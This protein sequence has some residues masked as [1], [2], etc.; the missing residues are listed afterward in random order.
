MSALTEK[1]IDAGEA[2]FRHWYKALGDAVANGLGSGGSFSGA[3]AL[4]LAMAA[5]A[6]S[7]AAVG[8]A[9]EISD[10]PP[11][12]IRQAVEQMSRKAAKP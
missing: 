11:D 12:S 5:R 10:I 7:D 6:L 8:M 4:G 3:Q 2:A 1:V 9:A